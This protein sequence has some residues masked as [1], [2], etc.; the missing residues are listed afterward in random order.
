MNVMSLISFGTSVITTVSRVQRVFQDPAISGD[1][2]AAAVMP[3]ILALPEILPHAT[4]P[5]E[6]VTA[7]AE[8]AVQ[9]YKE[10]DRRVDEKVARLVTKEEIQARAA[11]EASTAAVEEA[12]KRQDRRV[13]DVNQ[14]QPVSYQGSSDTFG[15]GI[16]LGSLAGKAAHSRGLYYPPPPPDGVI[17]HIDFRSAGPLVYARLWETPSPLGDRKL[18]GKYAGETEA[19]ALAGFVSDYP[20]YFG[21]QEVRRTYPKNPSVDS[22]NGGQSV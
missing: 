17:K 10:Y 22:G 6:L 1:K 8:A 7:M 11:T 15:A 19:E 12:A 14:D 13:Y 20:V 3:A 18:I 5:P 16:A 2:L 21:I 9:A 4:V